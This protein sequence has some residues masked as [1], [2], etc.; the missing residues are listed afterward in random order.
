MICGGE[1]DITRHDRIETEK[2]DWE[3]RMAKRERYD[4]LPRIKTKEEREME[5]MELVNR[6]F[7]HEILHQKSRIEYLEAEV[8]RLTQ[9]L[10]GRK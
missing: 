8:D 6:S 2:M 10:S 9:L 5:R 7:H 4:D 3:E 1:S